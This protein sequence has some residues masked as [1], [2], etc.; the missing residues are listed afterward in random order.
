SWAF[1]TPAGASVGGVGS[2]AS[3]IRAKCA[4]GAIDNAPAASSAD[5]LRANALLLLNRHTQDQGDRTG[6]GLAL[7]A[8]TPRN[9]VIG[10]RAHQRPVA[11]IVLAG[12]SPPG[13]PA[14]TIVIR[15]DVIALIRRVAAGAD[16][17]NGRHLG[18]GRTGGDA[19]A[20][21]GTQ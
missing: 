3:P 7:G 14:A 12:T 6:V 10:L 19:A 21:A 13:N 18:S 17:G 15:N 1:M 5:R 20:I 4:S 16:P 11:L 9:L 2:A 8:E